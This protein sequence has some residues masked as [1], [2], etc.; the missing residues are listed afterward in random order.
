ML[1]DSAQNQRWE[2]ESPDG[3]RCGPFTRAEL[4]EMVRYG[5]I[6]ADTRIRRDNEYLCLAREM[7]SQLRLN[8]S[9][10]L[11]FL[12]FGPDMPPYQRVEVK[13]SATARRT[14]LVFTI[15]LV[16]FLIFLVSVAFT[17]IW[18]WSPGIVF[19]AAG[20]LM[21]SGALFEWSWFFNN[22]NARGMRKWLGDAATRTTYISIGL[23][24]IS[25]GYVLLARDAVIGVVAFSL[26][27]RGVHPQLAGNFEHKL[28]R[29][30]TYAKGDES[31][32]IDS[33]KPPVGVIVVKPSNQ[34]ERTTQPYDQ[35]ALN[36]TG[37]IALLSGQDRPLE[38]WLTEGSRTRTLYT[39]S[40][41]FMSR[42]LTGRSSDGKH[43]CVV[44]CQID[45]EVRDF[46]FKIFEMQNARSV[47]SLEVTDTPGPKERRGQIKYVTLS[48]AGTL[49][50]VFDDQELFQ[51]WDLRY[52]RIEQHFEA[53]G[54]VTSVAMSD[55]AKRLVTGENDGWVKLWDIETGQQISEQ[56]AEGKVCDV[57]FSPDGNSIAVA[58][59]F[60]SRNAIHVWDVSKDQFQKRFTANGYNGRLRLS[61]SP[62]SLQLASGGSGDIIK[63]RS[64]QTGKDQVWLTGNFKFTDL[65]YSPSGNHLVA[66]SQVNSYCVWQLPDVP[67]TKSETNP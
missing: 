13:A 57:E 8:V 21:F 67:Q 19:C 42:T 52:G 41:K 5:E 48:S 40:C 23:V 45:K 39:P 35:V 17:P 56:R 29:P 18:Q 7:Y 3:T 28:A 34:F 16:G 58:H 37:Q 6:V 62:D 32:W 47:D 11:R 10:P 25:I 55:D 65:A 31:N 38:L 64:T 46:T 61:F 2:I 27:E 1:P 12:I 33:V 63:I 43:F 44:H 51:L 22:R 15:G 49:I 14:L 59:E 36:E 53:E 60:F 20:L 30:S 54:S 4:D 24:G 26:S 50:G 9:A 66:S